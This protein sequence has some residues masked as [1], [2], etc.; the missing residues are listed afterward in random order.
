MISF[1]GKVAG[2]LTP[3]SLWSAFLVEGVTKFLLE[4]GE[5][6]ICGPEGDVSVGQG[7]G[8]P[9]KVFYLQPP[10]PGKFL[11]DLGSINA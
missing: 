6:E 1:G 8:E 9:F 11:C 3:L 4:V 7:Q 5:S 10:A 2:A